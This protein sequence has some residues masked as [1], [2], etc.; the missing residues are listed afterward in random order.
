MQYSEDTILWFDVWASNFKYIHFSVDNGLTY[1]EPLYIIG[2]QGIRG[3]QGDATS[4]LVSTKLYDPDY[5]NGGMSP[6]SRPLFN[7]FRGN[8]VA[9]LPS[10]QIIIEQSIDS[11]VTWTE[12]EGLSD[13]LKLDFFSGQRPS[14][15]IPLKNGIRSCSCMIRITIT[16]MKYNVPTGTPEISKYDYWNSNYILSTERYCTFGESFIWLSSVHDYIHCTIQ[17]ATGAMPTNWVTDRVGYCSGWSGGNFIKLTES[18][19]GGGTNQPTNYWNWRFIFRT[20]TKS[21]DFDDS[22]LTTGIYQTF[23]QNLNEIQIAGK[24]T[25]VYSNNMMHIGKLYT[26]SRDQTA[27][28]PNKIKAKNGFISSDGSD[29]ITN[30]FRDQAGRLV[31]VKNGLITSIV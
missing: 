16:G 13:T 1:G 26:F 8:K 20:C 15:N 3:P 29:G 10:D 30:S 5:F 2:P 17:R 23:K 21:Y 14:I 22:K 4:S 24:A 25:W 11:G 19:F 7:V 18:N 9:F 28:F 6:I 27:T 31:T 12:L